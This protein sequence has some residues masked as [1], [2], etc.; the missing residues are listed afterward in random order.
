MWNLLDLEIFITKYLES[1]RFGDIYYQIFGIYQIW[2]YLLPNIW[3][4]LDLEISITRFYESTRFGDIY[5][6]IFGVNKI[7]R[8]LLLDFWKE[9]QRYMSPSLVVYIS[10]CQGDNQYS[11][12]NQLVQ[13]KKSTILAAVPICIYIVKM[14]C[15]SHWFQSK[16]GRK[17]WSQT[18]L[19]SVDF[20][21]SIFV[22]G[23]CPYALGLSDSRQG[24][25]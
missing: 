17:G 15:Q 13:Q 1:T 2:R 8:Y 18:F 3:N 5:C 24:V 16:S 12:I 14:W 21:D 25:R 19:S 11:R 10:S 9:I 4:L 22:P 7:W 23:A 6:Q 20:Q